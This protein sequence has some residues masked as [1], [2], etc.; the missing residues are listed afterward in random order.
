MTVQVPDD[1]RALAYEVWGDDESV[2]EWM[3]HPNMF[4]DGKTPLET[5]RDVD[6]GK[7]RV[8]NLLGQIKYGV[9]S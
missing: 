7:E 5:L 3:S 1:L 6:D 9:Y 4:L 8:R 2:R